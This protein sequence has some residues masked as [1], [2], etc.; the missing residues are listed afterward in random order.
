M[1]R[2]RH[3]AVSILLLA[4]A[5]CASNGGFDPGK[6]ATLGA[7][8]LA[9][10]TLDEN[11]VREMSADAARE[12]DAKNEVAA[13]DNPYSVR[14][15]RITRRMENFNDMKLDFKVYITPEINAFAMADGTVRVYSG[16][17]ELMPDDQ[18]YA[19]IGHEIGH[20]QLKHTY[21]QMREQL[22]T[23][24]AFQA[25][26]GLGGTIGKL[27][28]SQ[29]GAIAAQAIGARFSQEDELEADAYSAKMLYKQ[30]KDPGAMK[31]AIATLDKKTGSG[32]GPLSFLSSHPSNDQRK[33]ELQK[34]IDKLK[35]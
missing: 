28:S 4:L 21:K 13:K 15:R 16:L 30:G 19:V 6:A 1:I 18:V 12:M 26:A 14:L 3:I 2:I 23:S 24:T 29:L 35:Q 31:R 10:E 9:A 8:V 5:G 17:L 25:A 32:G 34:T 11:T 27:S 33:E 7:G 20:V 22:L